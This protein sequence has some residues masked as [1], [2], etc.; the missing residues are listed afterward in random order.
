[1][2]AEKAP[3]KE[4]VVGDGEEFQ[5]FAMGDP[6]LIYG[7]PKKAESPKTTGKRVLKENGGFPSQL[8]CWARNQQAHG[9][10][11]E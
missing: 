9:R 4:T 11:H 7:I 3:P 10:R 2:R 6:N 8:A 5:G 1:M